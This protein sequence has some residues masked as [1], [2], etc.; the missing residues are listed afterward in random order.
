MFTYID[1]TVNN[2]YSIFTGDICGHHCLGYGDTCKCGKDAFQGY[3]KGEHYCCSKATCQKD[4]NGN[5]ECPQGKKLHISKKCDQQC[6]SSI[7]NYIAISSCDVEDCPDSRYEYSTV[8]NLQPEKDFKDFC[9]IEDG[10]NCLMAN[11]SNIAFQQ[12]YAEYADFRYYF[13]R[14]LC[15]HVVFNKK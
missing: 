7:D 2:Y 6:P 15:F 1:H 8:C 12:C 5:V 3:H 10:K 13:E 14:K 4:N 11:N 9:R